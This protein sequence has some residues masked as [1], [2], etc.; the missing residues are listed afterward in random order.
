[1][2]EKNWYVILVCLIPLLGMMSCSDDEDVF[3]IEGSCPSG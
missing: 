2:R 1:M 3:G